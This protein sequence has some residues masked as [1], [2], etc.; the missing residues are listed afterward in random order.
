M[1]YHL[2]MMVLAE[3]SSSYSL[4]P[5]IWCWQHLFDLAQ[6]QQHF[7]TIMQLCSRTPHNVLHSPSSNVY[8]LTAV[9]VWVMSLYYFLEHFFV[10]CTT[11]IDSTCESELERESCNSWLNGIKFVCRLRYTYDIWSSNQKVWHL[12]PEEQ[13]FAELLLLWS[14][15]SWPS[16]LQIQGCP[17]S[18]MWKD[19]AHC[20]CPSLRSARPKKV[21]TR[22]QRPRKTTTF[23][24]AHSPL[25]RLTVVM[26]NISFTSLVDTYLTPSRFHYY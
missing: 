4:L 12:L 14:L 16:R 5:V 19:R 6:T 17:V 26:V 8:I 11:Y 24:M 25:M 9:C 15:K 3:Y 21:Q 10:L 22:R 23:W 18:F 13:Q 20:T 7:Q 2:I 1:Q